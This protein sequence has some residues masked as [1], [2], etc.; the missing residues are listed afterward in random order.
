VRF[1][2]K[3]AKFWRN[4]LLPSSGNKTLEYF[5]AQGSIEPSSNAETIH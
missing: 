3:T 4:V 5:G 2:K 1:G